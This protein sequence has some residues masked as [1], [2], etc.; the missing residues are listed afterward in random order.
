MEQVDN[1]FRR[2]ILCRSAMT[3]MNTCFRAIVLLLIQKVVNYFK[4][5][6]FFLAPDC[7]MINTIQPFEVMT[8]LCASNSILPS[9]R[10][11]APGTMI[12]SAHFRFKSPFF[13]ILI[14]FLVIDY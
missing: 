12:D 10:I 5:I 1:I 4:S 2:L 11:I 7:I 6:L 13:L 9:Y 8:Q 14:L 3:V